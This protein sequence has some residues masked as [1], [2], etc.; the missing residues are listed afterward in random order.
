MTPSMIVAVALC[1]PVLAWAAS[2]LACRAH[3]LHCAPRREMTDTAKLT[4]LVWQLLVLRF[5][6]ELVDGRATVTVP[7]SEASASVSMGP[8]GS[9]LL[10]LQPGDE[11]RERA[12]EH[13]ARALIIAHLSKR[14][15]AHDGA[16]P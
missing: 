15:S 2:R 3:V 13:E 14:P 9:F 16:S 10:E 7:R 4:S 1:V 8:A 11:H 5:R 12:T 6:V